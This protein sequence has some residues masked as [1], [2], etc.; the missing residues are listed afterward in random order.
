MAPPKKVILML[1]P[2]VKVEAKMTAKTT[3]INR[4][5]NVVVA[6]VHVHVSYGSSCCKG[7]YNSQ[8]GPVTFL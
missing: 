2:V 8:R 3:K 4:P 5:A 1:L 6:A 7:S